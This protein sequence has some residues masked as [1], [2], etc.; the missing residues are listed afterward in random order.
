MPKV[1][2]RF[3]PVPIGAGAVAQNGGLVVAGTS[4][5]AW[6]TAR[7][8]I[9][10]S[11]GVRGAEFTVWFEGD[12]WHAFI[13]VLQ[14][15]ARLDNYIGADAAGVGWYLGQGTIYVGGA[16]VASG[17]P[18][19]APGDVAG[20][21]V[22]LDGGAPAIEFYKGSTLV[23]SRPLPAGGPW[24]FG[25]SLQAAAGGVVHCAV[26]AGQWQGISP[27]VRQG[28][29]PAPAAAP[30]T[31][32]LS[33]VDYLSA[34]SDTPPHARY[35]GVVDAASL[36]TLAEI[37][38]WPW[39]DELPTQSSVAQLQVIDAGGVID[40][41][42]QQDL[43]GWPVAISL[44]DTEGTR[45]GASD[46]ARFALDYIEVQDDGAK[47]LHLRDAHD[48]LDEDLTRGV[49]LPSVP[50]LS[51]R[52]QPVVVGAVAS[53]PALPANSDGSV[54]FLAD[55][56]LAEVSVVLDRGDVMEPGTWSLTPDRQ[57]LLLTQAPVGPIVVDAS[58]IGT[59]MQP[60]TLEQALREIFRRIGK[61]A[62]SSSDAA[63][64]DAATGYAGIGYYAGDPISVRQ[65][66]AAILPSYGA[67]YWQDAAGVLRFTRVVDPSAVPDAQLA[68]DLATADFGDALQAY[69]DEAPHL[70]RRMAYQLNARPLA[71]SELVSDLVD[72]PAWRREELM[73]HWR[74]LAYSAQPLAPRYAHA[75]RTDPLVSC[76]WRQQDAQA[77]I[78]RVCAMYA[79]ARQR[80]VVTVL[81][82]AGPLPQ[83][84]Q[85][86]RITYDRYGLA[87][88][89]KV[90]VRRVESNPAI[91]AVELTVWG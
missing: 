86:G 81:D 3:A 57:Q 17:L 63:A 13:G 65:A 39:G 67:W 55:A 5:G 9:A 77:E 64:I 85:V 52:V 2:A 54:A 78:D 15:S 32:R 73:G 19:V 37:G 6:A 28:G 45:A 48:D 43:T 69:P 61:T 40:P 47:L 22:R 68:F 75:D 7:S 31:L 80:F 14:P 18:L 59:G 27:A 60:A 89:K 90:L 82:W 74:G 34:P 44:G 87:G 24:H 62:W 79:V 70:S 41:L 23:H 71:A 1:Y 10:H 33:D 50:S 8:D 83:P 12:S 30:L 91:G 16:V 25:A 38:F 49:F 11:G 21:L 72:V 58:S 84:G 29:W 46:V 66:L 42:L 53:V 20:V 76:F 26:N 51:W 35:E 56:P 36:V 4:I 88:G